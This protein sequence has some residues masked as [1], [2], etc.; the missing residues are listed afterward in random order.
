MDT[1]CQTRAMSDVRVPKHESL[2]YHTFF[3]FRRP[4]GRARC[5]KISL[6]SSLCP[7]RDTGTREPP[8]R[9]TAPGSESKNSTQNTEPHPRAPT[10]PTTCHERSGDTSATS[11]TER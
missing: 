2:E 5:P 7:V 8:R 1:F 4:G 10:H 9:G 6:V 3:P 11:A